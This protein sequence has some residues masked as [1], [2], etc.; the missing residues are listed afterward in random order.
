M[1]STGS[2]GRVLVVDD[3]VN[4]LELVKTILGESG[5][6]VMTT[7][8]YNEAEA[9]LR[10]GD[11]DVAILDMRLIDEEPYNV[12]G[13]ALLRQIRES[14]SG[15]RAVILTGYPDVN[16]KEIALN[17]YQADAYM[18]KVPEGATFDLDTF[19][20]LVQDLIDQRS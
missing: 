7:S 12:Q 1:V 13:M 18:E 20:Q 4:W 5:H 6:Q 14:S 19:S 10:S 9:L 3:H 2:T 11:F 16:Q 15:T 8:S 17:V